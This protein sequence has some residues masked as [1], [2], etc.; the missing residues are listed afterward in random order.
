MPSQIF[1]P[2]YFLI[3]ALLFAKDKKE[4]QALSRGFLRFIDYRTT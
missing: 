4:Q 2:E 1:L 3:I